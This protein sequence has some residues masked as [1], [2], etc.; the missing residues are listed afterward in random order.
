MRRHRGKRIN[1]TP[2]PE[3]AKWSRC[4]SALRCA[5]GCAIQRGEWIRWGRNH[6]PLCATCTERRYGIKPPASVFG[7]SGDAPIDVRDRQ[8]GKED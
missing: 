8:A 5:Y 1:V 4:R 3:S 6:T 7:C 2:K